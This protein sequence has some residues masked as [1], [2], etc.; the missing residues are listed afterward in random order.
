MKDEIRNLVNYVIEAMTD[1]RQDQSAETY[2]LSR[3]NQETNP[4]SDAPATTARKF[5]KIN[6]DYKEEKRLERAPKGP[7][8]RKKPVD[9]GYIELKKI[10]KDFGGEV[11]Q[12]G[13]D[14]KDAL[15]GGKR[16]PKEPEKPQTIYVQRTSPNVTPKEP[17]KPAN[18]YQSYDENGRVVF[19]D[20]PRESNPNYTGVNSP[21]Y[22]RNAESHRK[23]EEI[24][25]RNRQAQNTNQASPK[26]SVSQPSSNKSDKFYYGADG[27]KY[28]KKGDDPYDNWG[29]IDLGPYDE[30]D[31]DKAQYNPTKRPKADKNLIGFK[32]NTRAS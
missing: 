5:A 8:T 26:A 29:E 13:R 3:I 22:A 31:P 19:T 1:Y 10:A 14:V 7:Q 24:M 11:V 6:A 27:K 25:R 18:K 32:G 12:T 17:A 16:L 20:R 2:R 21:D 28:L 4:A 23:A 9:E 15:V 30:Q